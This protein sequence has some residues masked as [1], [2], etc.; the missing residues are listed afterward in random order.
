MNIEHAAIHAL[1]G[2]AYICC[3]KSG[4]GPLRVSS[5]TFTVVEPKR[6]LG[7]TTLADFILGMTPYEFLTAIELTPTD[8][9]VH[10]AMTVDAM[11]DQE[12]TDRLVA[13]RRNELANLAALVG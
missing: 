2:E 13:G 8:D 6:R 10:V 11:H 12:W 9:G 7:C 5:K 3:R 1:L 4:S